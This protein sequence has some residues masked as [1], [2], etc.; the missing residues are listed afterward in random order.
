MCLVI[1][2]SGI[3]GTLCSSCRQPAV[4]QTAA[5]ISCAGASIGGS[6][7]SSRR[8]MSLLLLLSSSL[9][10]SLS[11]SRSRLSFLFSSF[12]QTA[13]LRVPFKI[14]EGSLCFSPF[15]FFVSGCLTV[16]VN[17]TR[18]LQCPPSCRW[19]RQADHISKGLFDALECPFVG[20]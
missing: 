20:T 17:R 3:F 4:V 5:A 11:L 2:P 14:N 1:S 16:F 19:S 7:R 9:S 8:R 13:H 15:Y 12:L 10:L 6:R 18:N